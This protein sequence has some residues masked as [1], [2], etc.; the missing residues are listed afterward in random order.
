[1]VPLDLI[2][3]IIVL[4]IA[5]WGAGVVTGLVGASAVTVVTPLLVTLLGYDPF[6]AIGVSLSTDVVTSTI[7]SR[8]YFKKGNVDIRAGVQLAI[9]SVIGALI[10]SHLSSLVEGSHLGSVV[11]IVTIIMGIFFIRKPLS[12]REI[13]SDHTTTEKK[14]FMSTLIKSAFFGLIIG[15]VCGFVG[16]GGGVLILLILMFALGYSIHVA[17]GTSVFIMIFTALSGAVGH[18]LYVNMSYISILCCCIGGIIG[19]RSASTFA[20]YASADKLG[21]V[22]GVAFLILGAYMIL[23]QFMLA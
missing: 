15:V 13:G 20:N 9:F 14:P 16:A 22:A 10:G 7:S 5:G 4:F 6:T 12:S 21:R 18:A 3:S 11:A 17:V 1:M 2:I 19:A 23:S 8:I